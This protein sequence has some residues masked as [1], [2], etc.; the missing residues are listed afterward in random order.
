MP[1]PCSFTGHPLEGDRI[2][3]MIFF[4]AAGISNPKHEPYIV[5]AG[6]IL[7]ADKQWKALGHH[8]SEMAD[9]FAPPEHRDQFIFHATELFSGGKLF[10]RDR[11]TK[12][13]D[14][15]FLM[16]WSLFQQNSVCQL[17]GAECQGL[18]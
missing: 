7:N 18:W 13:T 16:N 14:G 11:Y 10:P 4:D 1:A 15:I 9:T 6:I 12:T 8:L 5:V 3:R 2:V 17:P